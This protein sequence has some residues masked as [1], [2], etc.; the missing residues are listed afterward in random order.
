MLQLIAFA[1]KHFQVQCLNIHHHKKNINFKHK[2][3]QFNKHTSLTQNQKARSSSKQINI[4]QL[5]T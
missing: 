1:L 3:K 4:K 5:E 2:P